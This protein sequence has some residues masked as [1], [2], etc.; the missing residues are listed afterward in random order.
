MTTGFRRL[1]RLPLRR[2]PGSHSTDLADDL[3][4]AGLHMTDAPGPLWAAGGDEA[5]PHGIICISLAAARNPDMIPQV[6]L[7]NDYQPGFGKRHRRDLP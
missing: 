2:G 6:P 4:R 3:R 5:G 7:P 1:V